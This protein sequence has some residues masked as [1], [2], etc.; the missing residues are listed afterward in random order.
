VDFEE[1]LNFAQHRLLDLITIKYTYLHNPFY[2]TAAQAADFPAQELKDW[3]A[4]DA[5]SIQKA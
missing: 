2:N 3:C 4:E 5:A 1:G